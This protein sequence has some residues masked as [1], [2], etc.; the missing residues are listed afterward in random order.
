[1]AFRKI[2]RLSALVGENIARRRK[3]LGITQEELAERLKVSG[4]AM[5]RIESGQ[6]APA[7]HV[8]MSSRRFLTARWLISSAVE[9]DL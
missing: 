9:A 8:W 1:M 6:A 3:Q 4:S 2:H 7:F 5:S